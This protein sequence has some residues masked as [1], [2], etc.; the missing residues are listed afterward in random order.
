MILAVPSF[1]IMGC[2]SLPWASQEQDTQMKL[3]RPK[4][5]KANIYVYRKEILNSGMKVDIEVD[6]QTVASTIANGYLVLQ[7]EPGKHTLVSKGEEKFVLEILVESNKNYFI[8]Q[9]VQIGLFSARSQFRLVDETVGKIEVAKCRL[10]ETTPVP[11][12]LPLTQK[13][14]VVDKKYPSANYVPVPIRHIGGGDS[15]AD[16]QIIIQDNVG[17][18]VVQKVKFSPGVSSSTVERLAKRFGCT[19]STGAGLITAKGPLEIY[20]MACDNG[21]TFM[22]QCELRQCRPAR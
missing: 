15:T 14:K 4:V 11:I 18:V 16:D 12:V 1:L 19:G 8:G 3:F 17:Y 13:E 7:L 9:E 10:I 22:A 21:T 6:G 5:G 2:A 20:R